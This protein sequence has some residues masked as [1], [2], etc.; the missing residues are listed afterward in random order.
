M[1]VGGATTKPPT[2]NL[3]PS[4]LIY[5]YFTER[6]MIRPVFRALL[7]S[8][9]KEDKILNLNPSTDKLL[10]DKLHDAMNYVWRTPTSTIL[11]DE[12]S[13]LNAFWRAFGYIIPGKDK[14]TDFP[15]VDRYNIEFNMTV[16]AI[17]ANIVDGIID[18]AINKNMIDPATLAQQ[19]TKL[20]VQLIIRTDNSIDKVAKYWEISY[21]LLIDLLDD[22]EL[23]KAL[24]ISNTTGKNA[25]E[26]AERLTLIG[27]K[28][29]VS[30]PNA[31]DSFF[32]LAEKM[33]EFFTKVLQTDWDLSKAQDLYDDLSFKDIAFAWG[34]VTGKNFFNQALLLRNRVPP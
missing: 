32:V 1:H 20:K 14:D 9:V 2:T 31:G 23:L 11:N 30:R 18:K 4:I 17:I 10:I 7:D 12:Q 19:L 22:A 25:Q 21:A 13:L 8:F 5:E 28:V 15:K 33:K 26:R 3:T 24:N 6:T 29:G 27:E 16:E 34:Q